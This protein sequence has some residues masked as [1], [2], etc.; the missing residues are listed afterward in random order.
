MRCHIW[1][2]KRSRL[3]SS[4]FYFSPSFYQKP[5][6]REME[7]RMCGKKFLCAFAH[8]CI[9]RRDNW[10]SRTPLCLRKKTK[11]PK[12]L[13]E[14][15]LEQANQQLFMLK[16]KAMQS[17]HSDTLNEWQRLATETCGTQQVWMAAESGS[18][19]SSQHHSQ[20]KQVSCNHREA[21][22]LL[23]VQKLCHYG[24][25][26]TEYLRA[27]QTPQNY[28]HWYSS[29]LLSS[30]APPHKCRHTLIKINVSGFAQS[31]RRGDFFFF[32][33]HL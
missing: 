21:S 24:R 29:K 23:L 25:V 5:W 6:I 16:G 14:W 22:W 2:K 3:L 15:L 32:K 19:E 13:N 4:F 28:Y 11:D 30:I 17:Q 10:W 12:L 33:K 20:K 7:E 31:N 18:C 26:H 9:L 27:F 1:L 8:S